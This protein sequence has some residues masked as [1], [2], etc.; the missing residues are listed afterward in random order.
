MYK[1]SSLNFTD[2]LRDPPQFYSKKS[3]SRSQRYIKKLSKRIKQ[4]KFEALK[5]TLTEKDLAKWNIL[6]LYQG[7]DKRTKRPGTF[8]MLN[9]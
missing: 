8:Q 2:I 3:K 4:K 6:N 9:G 1:L 7:I 5:T